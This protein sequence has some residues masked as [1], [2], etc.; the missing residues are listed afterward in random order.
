MIFGNTSQYENL[1]DFLSGAAD[2]KEF[3][4]GM[5]PRSKNKKL[6]SQLK[7]PEVK[8]FIKHGKKLWNMSSV[9]DFPTGYEEENRTKYI[10]KL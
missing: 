4:A 9:Q 8:E 2:I 10:K 1:H 5:Y 3:A 6:I 7:E